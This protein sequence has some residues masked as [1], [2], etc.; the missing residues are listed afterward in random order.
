LIFSY[1]LHLKIPSLTVDKGYRVVATKQVPP[2]RGTKMMK[3]LI[4]KIRLIKFKHRIDNQLDCH[5]W[6]TKMEIQRLLSGKPDIKATAKTNC[7]SI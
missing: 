6:A 1:K 5:S 3:K 2:A 4:K 7:P